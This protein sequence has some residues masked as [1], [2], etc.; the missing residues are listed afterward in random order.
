MSG[1]AGLTLNALEQA[2]G[3]QE[4]SNLRS[5]TDELAE[6][7]ADDDEIKQR[8]LEW[9]E[10]DALPALLD[11]DM[12]ISRKQK[13]EK[14]LPHRLFAGIKRSQ[15]PD[16]HRK[17]AG[18]V[19]LN[20][21]PTPLVRAV[22]EWEKTEDP[23]RRVHRLI[24]CVEV[25]C[26]LH[27]VAGLAAF[28]EEAKKHHELV[29]GSDDRLSPTSTAIAFHLQRPSLGHWWQMARETNKALDALA[30]NEVRVRPGRE[31]KEALDGKNNLISFR[32]SYAHGATPPEKECQDDLDQYTPVL[33][34]LLESAHSLAEVTLVAVLK[35]GTFRE[36]RGET[37]RVSNSLAKK[38]KGLKAG[39]CY[40]LGAGEKALDLHPLL[41]FDAEAP[42]VDEGT[43]QQPDGGFFFYDSLSG[44]DIVTLLNY[45]RATHAQDKELHSVLVDRL[46]MEEWKKWSGI[47]LSP[48]RSQMEALT[49]D[50]VGRAEELAQWAEFLA[51]A[52]RGFFIMQGPP[53]VGK[54]AVL[55]R[56]IQTLVDPGQREQAWA[57]AAKQPSPEFEFKV[58][59]Y[60]IRRDSTDTAAK[61]L[62]SLNQRLD[63]QFQLSGL[64]PGT[65]DEELRKGFEERL[66]RISSQLEGS[67][68]R[69]VL[70][71]DGL[72][73]ARSDDPLMS[74]LPRT[75]RP[76][77]MVVY[78]SRP[79]HSGFYEEIEAAPNER[80]ECDLEGLGLEDT[81]ALL[82]AH[83][84]KYEL[85]P[86]YAKLVLERS[87]GNPLSL[88]LL[89]QG[90][91][92]GTYEIND[93][94]A[95]PRGMEE[96]Y[97]KAL[98]K[99]EKE[100]PEAVDL[101][102]MLVAARDFVSVTMAAELMGMK[103]K[104][105]SSGPLSAAME[106]LYED[107]LTETVDDYQLFHQSLREH[108]K[109]QRGHDADEW[110]EK[111]AKW[112][113][114]WRRDGKPRHAA[115]R[116][117]Y[118]MTYAVPHHGACRDRAQLAYLQSALRRTS[119]QIGSV[120]KSAEVKRRG[121]LILSLVE[122][123]GWREQCFKASGNGEALRQ[124]IRHAQDVARELDEGGSNHERL[125]RFAR[126]RHDEPDRLYSEQLERLGEP[127][128][129]LDEVV[130]LARMGDS[131]RDRVMLALRA[132]WTPKRRK[133]LPRASNFE[134]LRKEMEKWLEE[135]QDS[136]LE[137][138]WELTLRPRS[139]RDAQRRA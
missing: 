104:K 139:A 1:K 108:L 50:F 103:E 92:Q 59:E 33:K 25:L 52:D 82:Y 78:G 65:S 46:P 70:V 69:L 17:N 123:K 20:D 66:D 72:D 35:D 132:L 55:A 106:L 6:T 58:V 16:A 85:D 127:D 122:D 39:H 61:M 2:L 138:S 15:Q 130:Q 63:A 134:L 18:A 96:L 79:L 129:P 86:D 45:P 23:F 31:L 30:L 121:E 94:T 83:V 14:S 93:P 117:R 89:C 98:A 84:N 77:I 9:W 137:T 120:K 64:G 133:N 24:D 75:T 60:F 125:L 87:E 80:T 110:E 128:L 10:I 71:I 100:S 29:R 27:S 34:T 112:C 76:N 68:K 32:N 5:F 114:D 11:A 40:L 111:L 38:F 4:R 3:D 7:G 47:E 131:S 57:K 67:K 136:A 13:E 124:A 49:G 118:A 41:S 90:L 12:E 54:S 21:L 95:L 116:A 42:S 53:G 62:E 56:M 73:E 101:L 28:V 8:F 113:S 97:Q 43:N 105:F 44:N 36:A 88:K 74:V 37:P 135:A 19:V 81:R 51:S 99:M 48:F 107:P 22:G 91:V 119:Q 115:E 102:L 126:W 26:K 109:E